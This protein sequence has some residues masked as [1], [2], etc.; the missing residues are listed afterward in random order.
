[1]IA[2]RRAEL[3][4]FLCALLALASVATAFFFVKATPPAEKQIALLSSED[5]GAL[6]AISGWDGLL[7]LAAAASAG[8]VAPLLGLKRSLAIG[9]LFVPSMLF[10]VFHRFSRSCFINRRSNL[11]WCF[12]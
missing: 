5:E 4:A 11:R 9:A 6:V 2:T 3:L 8:C 7:I 10:L 12:E 1:M